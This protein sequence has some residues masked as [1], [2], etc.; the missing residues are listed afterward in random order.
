MTE[1]AIVDCL[2]SSPYSSLWPFFSSTS[3]PVIHKVQRCIAAGI[4][5]PTLCVL[6][7]MLGDSGP[8][9]LIWYANTAQSLWLL[10]KARHVG[11]MDHIL[12]S[13]ATAVWWAFMCV[14]AGQKGTC[15]NSAVLPFLNCWLLSQSWWLNQCINT[16][17]IPYFNL[18][19]LGCI[20]VDYEML[21]L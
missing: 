3:T 7:G 8:T 20:K 4:N 9:N 15:I 12:N 17:A 2:D 5:I 11:T 1:K 21:L 16:A 14:K 10:W 6:M 18:Q 19:L 13:F